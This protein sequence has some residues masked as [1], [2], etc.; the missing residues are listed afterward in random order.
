MDDPT[1]VTIVTDTAVDSLRAARTLAAS[2]CGSVTA[3]VGGDALRYRLP[4]QSVAGVLVLDLF[5]DG[6]PAGLL[7]EL[8]LYLRDAVSWP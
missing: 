5:L 8:Q 3:L 4:R 1:P 2:G 7:G 6:S